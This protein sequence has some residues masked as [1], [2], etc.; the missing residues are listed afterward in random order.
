MTKAWTGRP[1]DKVRSPMQEV[2]E[3]AVGPTQPAVQREPEALPPTIT[4]LRRLTS[5]SEVKNIRSHT[6]TPAYSYF[7]VVWFLMTRT[8]SLCIIV[9]IIII[10]KIK[11]R[12][13]RLLLSTRH[14]YLQFVAW[15]SR[16]TAIC[17]LTSLSVHLLHSLWLSVMICSCDDRGHYK[18][19]RQTVGRILSRKF[20]SLF[21]F[22]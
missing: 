2:S 3:P 16:Q 14:I 13:Q 4:R 7:F 21:M 10:I 20:W 9:I 17:V 18:H 15:R 6:S 1:A 22:C 12:W 8:A 5:H 19:E 11:M